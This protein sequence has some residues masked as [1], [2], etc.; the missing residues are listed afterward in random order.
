LTGAHPYKTAGADI[1]VG[2]SVDQV[3]AERVGQFTR[4]P[5]LEVGLDKTQ[6]AGNCDSG[7]SC[8]YTSNIS[9]RSANSP[10]PK[11]V[12]PGALFDRL[13]GSEDSRQNA[14]VRAKRLRY[15]KSILDLVAEDTKQLQRQLGK[16]DQRKLDEFSTSLREIE[17]RVQ[18]ARS[19]KADEPKPDYQRP[20]GIPGEMTEHM[21]LILDLVALAYQMDIT[22]IS[23]VMVARD[24]SNRPYPWLGITEGHHS[25]SHHGRKKENIERIQKIDQYHIQQFAYF[26]EKLESIKEGEGTLLDNCMIMLGSGIGDGDR[27][28]HDDLPVLFAGKGGGAVPAGMHLHYPQ[29]TPLCNLYLSML[30]HMGVRTDRFGDSTGPLK[31]MGSV[32]PLAEY[33]GPIL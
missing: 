2:V 5:S 4:L 11:E 30:N 14:E 1:R 16:A 8:A 17:R 19:A 24:G 9:W 18:M 23:T 32:Q 10:V 12:D 6:T 7:Y 28:N 33:R 21:R 27:H 29:N 15:R 13:F 31:G 3:A 26:L 22:R 20:D 25:I